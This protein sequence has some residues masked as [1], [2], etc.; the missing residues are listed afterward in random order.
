M[1]A[2]TSAYGQTN[3]HPLGVLAVLVLGIFVFALP[4]RRALAPL[5]IAA[6]MV[7][8][9]QRLA[10]G[11]A[12]FTLLRLLL[13]MY[14]L[15]LIFKGEIG[16]FKWNKIDVA[17]ILWCVFGT[18][19]MSMALGT[20]G[21]LINRLGWSYDVLGTYFLTRCIVRDW[22]DVYAV[23]KLFAFVSIP[24][25]LFF[26]VEWLTSYN[27]FSIL[28]GVS[29]E[30][31]VRHG[32]L[33]CQGAFSHPILAG[34]FWAAALPTIWILLKQPDNRK[35]AIRATVACFFIIYACGSSTPI[36]STMVGLG[37]IFIFRFRALVKLMW[38]GGILGL[39]VLHLIM[40]KPV[41]H[42]MARV[43]FTG[44]ST[45]WHRYLIFDTFLNN[46]DKWYLMGDTNPVAWG[47][48]QM[49]D[50]TNQFIVEGLRGGL[51]TLLTFIAV[52][53]FCF[54]KVGKMLRDSDSEKEDWAY[55]MLGSAVFVHTVTFFG[56]SYF[57]QMTSMLYIQLA[58][59]ACV[60]GFR[61]ALQKEGAQEMKQVSSV[62]S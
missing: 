28:G 18:A 32:K 30:T 2:M 17:V 4:R 36:L 39:G 45:G 5:V 51:L 55:W 26:L 56:V 35:L 34:T 3:L 24:V 47:V 23:A 27:A 7:P 40:T 19:I 6:A 43:D 37:T 1:G 44:G 46:F 15:R 16:Q 14:F 31:V 58:L 60:A 41:W 54:G 38:I 62:G 11:G 25:S 9:S 13:L 8:M 12:D 53:L 57:G 48:W 33:R 21:A 20:K 29:A 59:V 52:L 22:D 49:A 50:P 61:A 42:L 10:I